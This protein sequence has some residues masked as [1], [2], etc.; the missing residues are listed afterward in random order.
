MEMNYKGNVMHIG[1]PHTQRSIL[2]LDADA[3]ENDPI[4][5]EYKDFLIA[6]KIIQL[7]LTINQ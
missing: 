7:Y 1:A 2:T 3:I 4:F 5:A 6:V